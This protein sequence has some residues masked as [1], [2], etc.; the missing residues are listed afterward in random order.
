[1][2]GLG[3]HRFYFVEKVPLAFS[4]VFSLLFA[5]TLL[6]LLLTFA[7]KYFL[8]RHGLWV[9]SWYDDHS[10]LVQFRLIGNV[11]R[12]SRYISEARSLHWP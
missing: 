4:F 7:G 9:F 8:P 2:P 5:N 12:D 3:G 11:G 10:I 6:M 1:M